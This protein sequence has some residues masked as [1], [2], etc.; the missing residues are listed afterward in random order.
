MLQ[1]VK[2]AIQES[3]ADPKAILFNF[4]N[5]LIE[6][7]KLLPQ[8]YLSAEFSCIPKIVGKSSLA[9]F[10]YN[11]RYILSLIHASSLLALL[12]LDRINRIKGLVA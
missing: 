9:F 4:V 8:D 2:G 10:L 11:I 6:R 3:S 5:H 7:L 12:S 1:R